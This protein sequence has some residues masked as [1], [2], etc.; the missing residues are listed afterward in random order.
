MLSSKKGASM[1]TRAAVLH[2]V[3]E[4][5]RIETL[6][7]EPPRAGEVLVKVAAAGIC[8]SDWHV[9]SGATAHPLPVLLGHEGAG[10]VEA[11]GPGVVNLHPGSHVALNWAPSCGRC[12]YC[13]N[14]SPSLCEAF[15]AATW[16]GAMMDG[17]TRFSLDGK[18]VCQYCS[19]GCFSEWTVVPESCC[20][21]LPETVPAP[22]A[23]LIGCAVMTGVGAVLNT[24]QV[25][26]GSSVA[27]FGAGGVGL[28]AVLGAKLAGAGKII[29]VDRA[30]NKAEMAHTFG[31]TDF[32]P[33]GPA[34]VATIRALT[35][36][37][38]ADFTVEAVGAPAVQE[39]CFA[40]ARP[41]GAVI[42][43]GLSAMGSSTNLPGAIITRQAKTVIGSYYGSAVPARDFPLLAG[44]YLQGRLELDRL[45][46]RTY[47]LD[48]INE[49][50]AR[51]LAGEGARSVV[52]FE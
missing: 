36:G 3:G 20:V 50:Y 29:V 30:E 13:L 6:D 33:A 17:T 43:A 15:L 41:G 21:P 24:A 47:P 16:A 49:A 32:V 10:V 39:A 44:L 19:L 9:A 23:A 25:R 7:L 35:G 40:A 38:G 52:R 28:S 48:A 27:V 45:I 12:F 8:H 51:M 4:P 1:Q 46:T 5:I 34:A 37:R 18:P 14:G 26:P 22:V 31:A 2:H 42:L 11:V